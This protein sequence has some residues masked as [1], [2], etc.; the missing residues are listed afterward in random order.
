MHQSPCFGLSTNPHSI[1][2]EGNRS[3]GSENGSV[4]GPSAY[5]SFELRLSTPRHDMKYECIRLWTFEGVW[6]KRYI[7]PEILARY[8]FYYTR[9][10]DNVK[11][12]F[13]DIQIGGWEEGDNVITEHLR[14]SPYCPLMRK[15]PTENVPLDPDFLDSVPDPA[16]DVTSY[17]SGN[18]STRHYDSVPFCRP[19]YPEYALESERLRSL[20]DWPSAL[21]QKPQQLCDAGFF[22]TGRGDQVRCYYCG[23]GLM[24]WEVDDDPWEQHAMWYSNCKYLQQMKDRPFIER[25]LAKKEGRSEAKEEVPSTSKS[26]ASVATAREVETEGSDDKLCKICYEI[27]SVISPFAVQSM[28]IKT[29]VSPRAL[30][31]QLATVADS[32]GQ[33][34]SRYEQRVPYHLQ[35][36]TQ[37]MPTCRHMPTR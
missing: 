23:G 17:Q 33:Q 15:H 26:T 7:L 36:L 14:W 21:P 37:A 11:C 22:Y 34:V 30:L 3:T 9:S 1:A 10:P 12:H 35:V 27:I 19:E 18:Q 6:T 29:S 31:C 13:C 8:G 28:Y 4:N 25:C 5:K 32:T 16:P 24:Q 20:A 2:A